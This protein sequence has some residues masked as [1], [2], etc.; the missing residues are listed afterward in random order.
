[1]HNLTSFAIVPALCDTDALAEELV[2][3]WRK[4]KLFQ[5]EKIYNSAGLK[6]D[7]GV[8]QSCW[9]PMGL[10]IYRNLKQYLSTF[11]LIFLPH[12]REV[13]TNLM[14]QKNFDKRS[15]PSALFV[16]ADFTFHKY[17]LDCLTGDLCQ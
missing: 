17:C 13:L 11:E 5:S 9:K 15:D 1:M 12:C 14:A 6:A 4:D 2:S 8:Q 10:T 16:F 3:Q 7:G